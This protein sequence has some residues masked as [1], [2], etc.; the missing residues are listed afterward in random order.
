MRVATPYRAVDG[1]LV[2]DGWTAWPYLPGEHR[3][4]RWLDV[5][6][7]GGR[8]HRLMGGLPCPGWV[9]ERDDRWARADRVAFG[10]APV[11][12]SPPG[13]AWLVD[14]LERLRDEP[15]APSQLVHADLT[16]NVLLHDQLPP[17]VIDL[18][19][20]WRPP[21]FAAAVVVV[22]ALVWEGADPSLAD[23]VAATF[24]DFGQQLARAL[25]FRV[26]SDAAH[27]Q[28][29]YEPVRRIVHVLLGG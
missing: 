18:S 20:T 23:D 4:G 6:D 24:D 25:V 22:D 16:G 10:E 3:P 11:P 21:A 12:P 2:V 28:A 7:T 1:A 14:L 9:A 19:L 8:L 17:A 27:E 29:P 15:P 5:V 26:L 13:G